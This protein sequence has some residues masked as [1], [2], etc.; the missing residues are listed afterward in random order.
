MGWLD[1]ASPGRSA[2]LETGAGNCILMVRCSLFRTV[3]PQG[4]WGRY[5]N[6]S[7]RKILCKAETASCRAGFSGM[8]SFDHSISGINEHKQLKKGSRTG[9]TTLE[10]RFT[11]TVSPEPEEEMATAVMDDSTDEE[12]FKRPVAISQYNHSKTYQQA[13]HAGINRMWSQWRDGG[14]DGRR[15]GKNVNCEK[16]KMN[17]SRSSSWRNRNCVKLPARFPCIQYS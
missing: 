11:V 4:F 2:G 6:R 16:K 3:P 7:G 14:S 15:E 1:A 17:V 8:G 13:I 10:N 5:K 12:N 9:W